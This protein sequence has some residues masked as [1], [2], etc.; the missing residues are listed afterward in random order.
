MV[1]T[2]LQI[3]N[4]H[5]VAWKTSS[6]RGNNFFPIARIIRKNHVTVLKFF[7]FGISFGINEKLMT[8][9]YCYLSICCIYFIYIWWKQSSLNR[10]PAGGRCLCS[11]NCSSTR[12]G[13]GIFR[14]AGGHW[15]EPPIVCSRIRPDAERRTWWKNQ[16]FCQYKYKSRSRRFGKRRGFSGM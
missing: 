8:T 14:S 2:H 6:P 3:I 5:T 13:Q 7:S 15:N 4:W 1:T 16:V 9:S 10:L 11:H 12:A